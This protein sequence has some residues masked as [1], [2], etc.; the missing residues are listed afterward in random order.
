MR[1]K[2][3]SQLDLETDMA[4]NKLKASS[5][6]GT[7][8]ESSP[9]IE[10]VTIGTL[11][12]NPRNGRT[13]SKKQ[14]KQIAASIR[15]FGF[16]NPLIVDGDNI[17]LAG[18]GRLAAARL[19]GLTHV[20]VIRFHHLSMAQ[21]RAYVIADNKIAEQAGWDRELLA[22]E[23]GE[24]VDLLPAEG[25]DVSLTGF[26][27]AEID[28]LLADMSSGHEPEDVVP[29]LPQKA[30]ARPGDLR[31]LAKHRLLCGDA[32]EA[33]N[34][35]HLMNGV[36]AAAVFCDPPYNVRVSSIG[37]RGRVR[38]S[39][40]A[41]G[42]GEMRPA[43]YRQFLCE[44]LGNGARVSVHGA[45]HYVCIDWRHI[46][47][48]IDVGCE[49]YGDM[50]NLVVWNK[51]NAGQGSFYRSQHELIGVFRMGAGPHRNNVELG[52]FGRNRSNV[53]TYP[54]V[55]TF[56]GGRMEALATHPTIKPVALVAD[57]LLDCTAKG[58]A[59]LDQFVGSGTTILAAQ[60]VGR[61][62]YAMEYEPKYV[63]AAIGRWQRMTKIEAT[64][65]DDGRTFEEIAAARGGGVQPLG[66][67]LAHGLKGTK[68][69]RPRSGQDRAPGGQRGRDSE[70][71]HG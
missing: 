31:L 17:V 16:I 53:W 71:R 69:G 2:S 44:T 49:L 26:E 66:S 51:T 4:A 63:D 62:A 58:E 28:L 41:F 10:W 36:A 64:L 6:N 43:Q 39:E 27:A 37:G 7:A 12:P 46:A 33:A 1:D 55:N 13:H 35:G 9:Q 40:F 52:R 11:R 42:S 32:R 54:G 24:L 20:P 14:V 67:S 56:G 15:Q 60:K 8:L 34:F 30:V 45:V 38:H 70:S 29:P 18:G 68:G 25:M 23:L 21:K 47:H 3:W 22:V 61:I 57:A 48:L 5:S 19:N 59:V 50:L 65:A